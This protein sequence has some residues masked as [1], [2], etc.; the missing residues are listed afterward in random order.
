MAN[1][2]DLAK[3][4]QG[5]LQE[6]TELIEVFTKKAIEGNFKFNLE[7]VGEIIGAV[8]T[9]I[10]EV[11]IEQQELRLEGHGAFKSVRKEQRKGRN[12]QTGE[13]ILIPAK[14]VVTWKPAKAFKEKVAETIVTY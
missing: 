14:Q 5:K 13:E 9:S 6:N 11:T 2:K 7:E 4:V 3:V 1:K 10:E 12:P 8:I